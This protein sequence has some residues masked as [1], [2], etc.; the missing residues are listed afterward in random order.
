MLCNVDITYQVSDVQ[1]GKT[2]DT[3]TDRARVGVIQ[4]VECQPSKLVA[5][6]RFPSLTPQLGLVQ[7]EDAIDSKSISYGFDSHVQDQ[8]V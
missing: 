2:L 5:W 6:V 4:M 8:I 3:W 1:S 7:L